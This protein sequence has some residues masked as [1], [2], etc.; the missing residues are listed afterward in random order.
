MADEFDTRL[1]ERL[2]RLEE[3]LPDMSGKTRGSGPMRL[4]AVA[5]VL[6]GVLGVATGA[7]A[8]SVLFREVSGGPVSGVFSP[9]G[10][11]YCSRLHQMAPVAADPL[12][13]EL[14]YKVIWQIEDRDAKTSVQSSTPPS[15]GFI[16]EGA[17]VQG[18]RSWSWNAARTS[19]PMPYRCP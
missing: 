1:K 19:S 17:L 11:L 3:G 14:G 2:V 13:R 10:P 7:A 18:E 8:T 16:V 5:L 4:S 9:G 12:L 6:I 15:A